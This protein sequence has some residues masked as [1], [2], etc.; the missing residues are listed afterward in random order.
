M[1]FIEMGA[2]TLM[3]LHILG[4]CGTFMA[5]IAQ[6]AQTFGHTVTGIDQQY[7]PPMSDILQA[8]GI[9]CIK[10]YEQ[11][12][13]LP[14][15]DLVIIGNALSRGNPAVEHILNEKIP[16]VSGP[17]WLAKEV[18]I[19]KTVLAVAGTHGKTT[20]SSLLAWVLECAGLEP[21]FL[22]GGSPSNF[23]SSAR[24]GKGQYFVIEADEYDTAF[25]DK[26]SKFIHYKPDVLILNNIEFDHADIFD[27]LE[28]ILR[29]FQHLLRTVP[30]RGTVVFNQDD[31]NINN[32]LARGCWSTQVPFGKDQ[33][34]HFLTQVQ[35][36]MHGEYN[37]LNALAAI[38]AAKAVGVTE[39]EAIKA[40]SSFQGVKRRQEKIAEV[41]TI[42]LFEDFAHHPTA[43]QQ[44]LQGFKD[45][46]PSQRL[47]VLL[48]LAS[49]TMRGGY[50]HTQLPT[51]LALADTYYIHTPGE[52]IE[53][54]IK[55]VVEHS[56]PHDIMVI[57]S[58]RDFGGI[59]QKLPKAL[60]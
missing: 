26:R 47:I 37:A 1:T 36:N 34:K 22:I 32:V 9:V 13:S 5:G 53:S 49:N 52:E 40:L 57:M 29:Q 41:N 3:N 27:S 23:P 44:T 43:I 24:L 25:F 10:G 55:Q 21:S 30:A 2:N 39:T 6:I 15:P 56:R 48:E 46:F 45:R 19:K 50:H 20:T 18:L 11:Y 51:A 33:L 7:Y 14:K 16:Y 8:H 31:P 28:A 59:Y 12:P 42:Q 38:A 60:A 58:N 35:W 4:V 54:L 17:E